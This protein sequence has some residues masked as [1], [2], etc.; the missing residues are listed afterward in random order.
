MNAFD[1]LKARGVTRLCHFT[2]L[3][4]L[5]T[6]LPSEIGILASQSIRADIKNVTD[7]SRYD[8][9]LGYVCCSVE[10]PN[11]WFLKKAIQR[12]TN[13][14]FKDWVVL[15]I[16]LSILELKDA[17][18][19]PCNA[20]TA[21]GSHINSNMNEIDLIF[22][23][24][25]SIFNYRRTPD[26]LSCCPTN[27][28]AEILIKNNVPR[29]FISGIAVGCK[30][31]AEL[32]YATFKTLNTKPIPLYVAPEVLTPDWSSMIRQGKRPIETV[33]NWERGNY[34]CLLLQ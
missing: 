19:C 32:I 20:S 8:G 11:S 15:Y 9:E 17:K 34:P 22:A 14:I 28:Q 16:D 26:M 7:T 18:F 30:S 4:S 21:H 33:C 6:I 3:E 1:I 10:Y 23:D 24:E 12:D 13:Q 27:G 2:K 5:V 31:I 25:L 29:E